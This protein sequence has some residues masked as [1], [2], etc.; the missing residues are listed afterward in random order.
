MWKAEA[1]LNN[2]KSSVAAD[3]G[4]AETPCQEFPAG[5]QPTVQFGKPD[6]ARANADPADDDSTPRLDM[7]FDAKAP[8]FG[9]YEL[10]GEIGRGGMGIIY[11]ARHRALDRIVALKVNRATAADSAE[12]VRRFQVEAEAVAKLDHP[13]IVP[14]FDVG[15]VQG[16]QYYSMAYVEGQSLA[17]AVAHGP[18]PSRRAAEIVQAVVDAVAYAHSQG[19]IHRDIKPE[20]ILLDAT[21]RPRITDFGIAKCIDNETHL[22][23]AGEAIGTPSYMPP[24][25]AQGRM[26]E[27]GPQADV[28]SLGATL[29]CLLTGRPPFAAATSLDTFNL[30]IEREP[31]SPRLL[32]S[33]LDRDLE[34]IVLKCLEKRPEKRYASAAEL[35]ADLSRYLAHKPIVA[36]PVGWIQKSVRWCRRNPLPA[37]LS[38]GLVAIVATAFFLVSFSYLGAK[39]ARDE[40]VHHERAGRFERYVTNMTSVSSALQSSNVAI[41]FRSLES[42]PVEHRD[43]EWNYFRRQLDRAECKIPIL[44]DVQSCEFLSERE[45]LLEADRLAI[46]SPISGQILRTFDD[47]LPGVRCVVARDRQSIAYMADDNTIV[48]RGLVGPERRTAMQKTPNPPVTIHFSGDGTRLYGF[49][50]NHH[51]F[52]VWESS[53]GRLLR[54][55]ERKDK[56]DSEVVCAFGDRNVAFFDPP[57]LTFSILDLES[58]VRKSTLRGLTIS[59]QTSKFTPDGKHFLANDGYPSNLLQMWDV[60]TGERVAELRG[61]QNECRSIE[62]DQAGERIVTASFDQTVRVWDRMG[63]TITVLRGH[64]G[65]NWHA[66]IS[67][68]GKRVVSSSQ[69]RTVR[70]WDIETG[71]QLVVLYGHSNVV[72]HCSYSPDGTLIASN[73][74]GREVRIWNAKLAERD[75]V[76][77]GHTGFVYGV[78]FHPDGERIASASWDGTIR[79]AEATTGRLLHTL[80]HR[81][82]ASLNCVAFSPNGK[83]LAAMDR[84]DSVILW[85]FESGKQI[86]R[87]KLDT[88]NWLNNRLAFSPD[89]RCIAAG[90][91]NGGVHLF[92]VDTFAE[93]ALFKNEAN[94]IHD[95]CFSPDGKWLAVSGRRSVSTG[96]GFIWDLS[97]KQLAHHLE[98]ISGDAYALAY[99]PDGKSLICGSLDGTIKILETRN[100][101]ETAVYRLGTPIY[102]LAVTP[103]ATRLFVGTSDNGI[104]IWDLPSG[105]EVAELRGHDSYVHA[106]SLSPDGSRLASASGDTTVRIWD[107]LSN[108]D[109]AARKAANASKRVQ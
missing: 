27:V 31:V 8:H 64:N 69:D 73:E 36:R 82:N 87:W 45:F 40:A 30:V 91:I 7:G 60:E 95:V 93:A 21:G 76:L 55:W 78:A 59:M 104:R 9:N 12:G 33:A 65:W 108:T 103:D 46:V 18:L 80:T 105:Q 72:F 6:A 58:G 1:V 88:N 79:I 50:N 5:W 25:Q 84:D 17:A 70:L 24:E 68:D 102:S 2:L 53:T 14:I 19:V 41:A 4:A 3:G 29:Y 109:R 67:P 44:G 23:H 34:T 83:L 74:G 49:E 94:A 62:F 61:H 63:K 52:F 57:R 81:K 90:E 11:K 38:A 56:P 96:G 15:A 75:G 66:E 13:A 51:S 37:S 48:V 26:D 89:G 107:T 100:W 32:N 47:R 54:T 22:T 97:T 16:Q 35:A 106:L 20:N 86:H 42:A 99:T 39:R 101:T 92:D 98:S 77:R 10:L 28:Y 43:W 85:D 71:A